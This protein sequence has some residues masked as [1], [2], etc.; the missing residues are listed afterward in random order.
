MT[1]LTTAMIEEVPHTLDGRDG[2]LLKKLGLDLKDLALESLRVCEEDLDLGALRVAAVPVSSGIGVIPTFCL[3]VCAITR[4]LGMDSFV[5]SK[6]DVAG[7]AE[8]IAEGVDIVFMADDEEFVALNIQAG[9]FSDN[10]RSTALGYCTAL[11]IAAGGLR[12]KEVLVIGAGRMGQWVIEWLGAAGARVSLTE[13][14][15]TK[16]TLARE[17]FGATVV[18]SLQKGVRNA[19]LIFNASPAQ[20]P[21]SWIK[22]GAIISSPGVPYG[23]DREGEE[24]ARMI[25]HDPLQIGVAVMAIWSAMCSG[26]PAPNTRPAL[27]WAET[28]Q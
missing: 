15:R 11:E 1:R 14:D 22:K 17:Q 2:D 6:A 9:T 13:T 28:E 3:S 26:R 23:F 19:D 10:T 16:A 18:P 4:H 12:G 20:I 25:I 5:T 27:A 21:G 7:M 8:A 24:K